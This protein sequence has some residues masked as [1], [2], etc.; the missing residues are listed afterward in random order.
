MLPKPD[1]LSFEYAKEYQDQTVVAAYK[2]R[3]P[4]PPETY[5]LLVALRDGAKARI[6][7]VGCGPG[8]LARLLAPRVERVDA[9]DASPPMIALGKT[10]P[11]GDCPTLRWMC[12]RV[13]DIVFDGP[14]DL[15]TAGESLHWMDWEHVFPCFRS[16]LVPGGYLVLA[17]R[18]EL[19]QTWTFALNRLIMHYST[20]QSYKGHNIVKELQQRNLFTLVGQKRTAPIEYSQSVENYL[21]ALHSR[22]GL[23]YERLN[24]AEGAAFDQAVRRLLQPFAQNDTLSLK[25]IGEV[26]WGEPTFHYSR[27]F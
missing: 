24:P 8:D 23:S 2:Y 25:I 14:Y 16:F 26:I 9:V 10:L 18:W 17:H 11:E 22:N 1:H 27:A 12:G 4:Y 20:Y 6:L 7:D 5:D 3:I 13:E 19:P 21:T 15:I